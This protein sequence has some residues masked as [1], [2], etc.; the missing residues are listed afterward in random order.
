[1][2]GKKR[3]VE[4]VAQEEEAFPRGGGSG[5][6]PIV[7]KQI[8]EDAYK[9]AEA[10]LF[11][12][13]SKGRGKK[14]RKDV[15]LDSDEEGEGDEE[16][17]FFRSLAAQDK[18]PKYVEL[19]KF[20]SLNEGTK[21]WGTVVEILAKELIISLPHGLRGHVAFKESSDILA[22]AEAPKN[23]NS[24][25]ANKQQAT[26]GQAQL[27]E[28]FHVGQFVRCCV[29]R[30]R[31]GTDTD[32]PTTPGSSSGKKGT[33]N[34]RKRVD[35]SL[36]VSKVNSGLG[37]DSVREGAALPACVKSVE[38][39]GYLVTF[40][41]RGTT[42]FLPKKDSPRQLFTG[43]LVDVV[44]QSLKAGGHAIV[45]AEPAA[46]AA[47]TTKEWDGLNIGTLLPGALVPARVRHVLSD[48]LLVSFLTFFTGT[49][50]PFH[51]GPSKKEEVA[52][53]KDKKK[54]KKEEE[55]KKGTEKASLGD[56]RA[57]YSEN[58][59]IK[60]R[61]LF[62]D[63]ASKRVGL[64]LQRHLLEWSLPT[65]FPAQGQTFSA[66][67]VKRVDPGLG[68]LLDLVDNS[69][70]ES[71]KKKECTTI[72]PGYAHISNLADQKIDKLE[73][74]YRPGQVLGA[75]VIGLRPMDGLASLSLK[76]SVLEQSF[77]G[78][79]DVT[80][81]MKVTGTV[82]KSDEGALIVALT[83]H[84]K[85]LV[86]GLHMS[87]I[88]STKAYK[89]YKEGQKVTGKVLQVDLSAKK[90]LLTLKPS[91]VDSKL[92]V[93]AKIEDALPGVK[94]HG[95]ITGVQNYGVFITFF[96]DLSGLVPLV[97]CGLPE[98]QTPQEAFTI[99]SVI[100]VRVVGV[101]PK[102]NRLKLS[103]LGKKKA[104]EIAEE[105]EGLGG[106]QPGELVAGVVTVL[107]HK[108]GNTTADEE[109]DNE[110]LDYAEVALY[111]SVEL[112]TGLGNEAKPLATGRLEKAH[113]SDHPAAATALAE[114]LTV[115]SQFPNLLVLQRLETAK[116]LRVTRK[117]SLVSAAS[118]GRLP[119]EISALSEGATYPGYVA[120]VISDGV[121]VRFLG[122]LTG[123]AGLPQLSDTFVSDPHSV[124]TTGQSVRAQV[125]LIDS[126][127]NRFSLSLK[128]SLCGGGDV[129]MLSSFFH[130]AELAAALGSGGSAEVGAPADLDWSQTFAIGSKVEGQVHGVRDYGTLCDLAAHSD[131]VGLA[132]PTQVPENGPTTEGAPVTAVVLDYSKKDG[133]VDLSLRHE[134]VSRA[135]EAA[136][137]AQP[138]KK[139]KTKKEAAAASQAL[140]CQ[141]GDKISVTVELV[142]PDEGYAV[143]SLPSE[144]T[145]A[146]STPWL[147]YLATSDFNISTAAS[148]AGQLQVGDEATV[149]VAA[150]PSEKT[151][152]RLLLSIPLS[153]D[154]KASAGDG[155]KQGSGE[156][157]L[158]LP[159]AGTKL[160]GKIEAVHALHADVSLENGCRGRIYITEITDTADDEKAASV[161]KKAKKAKS[162]AKKG[163]AAEESPSSSSLSSPVSSLTIGSSIEVVVLGRMQSAE[164]KRHGL[165]ELSCRP[166]V[167]AAATALTSV[168]NEAENT[169]GNNNNTTLQNFSLQNLMVT[170]DN[171]KPG[172][173]LPGYAQE[174]DGEHLW[175]VFSPS[176][177]GRVFL[178]QSCTSPEECTAAARAYR[179]GTAITATVL[180]VNP[181]KHALDVALGTNIPTKAE[182]GGTAVGVVVSANG[183]GVQI[184]I[185]PGQSGKV[186]LT[187]IHD[188]PVNNALTGLK[189]RQFVHVGII[190]VGDDNT[191]SKNNKRKKSGDGAT[192]NQNKKNS[193]QL[194]L[195]PSHGGRCAAHTSSTAVLTATLPPPPESLD[196]SELKPGE[197]VSGYVKSSGA[198]GVFICL[199]RGIDARIKLRQLSDEFV[200]NVGKLYP[201]GTYVEGSV[202][203]VEGGRVEMTLRRRR[204]APSLEALEE[205]QVVRGRVKRI[206][207][208]GVFVE[209]DGTSDGGAT[210][211]VGPCGLAHLSELADAYVHDVDHLFKVDQRVAA[212]VLGVD[213]SAGRLSLGLKPSYFEDIS[214]VEEEGDGVAQQ[215]GDDFDD[216]LQAAAMESDKD[217]D[218]DS[219]EYG[220]EEERGS[221]S[222]SDK[223]PGSD[224]DLDEDLIEA[225][226]EEGEESGT[227]DDSE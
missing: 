183:T 137:G 125:A 76:Q 165:L 187:D 142:K 116:Q 31:E 170:W 214:D 51:L 15:H 152:G 89:K 204:P 23:T 3:N 211:S 93:L 216:E 227:D 213:K 177:R 158:K 128:R 95:V 199:A 106:L 109:G 113:L 129:S 32:T 41:I 27:S 136:A 181:G 12:S 124:F 96:N 4:L 10:D 58:Q 99:G 47:A 210:T 149:T 78:A 212:R 21:L 221:D 131:V 79:G 193:L 169:T 153:A 180:S 77:L 70:A 49:V 64:S 38:D 138:A 203:G 37:A 107:H 54:K 67:V 101:E 6:A 44:V 98:G 175:V 190:N 209:L 46:V 90:L 36:H 195:R 155:P 5:L 200:E 82:V 73:G 186:A 219:E 1:M 140:P 111:R 34:N 202:M 148:A 97:E 179:P 40:G 145:T 198:T 162:A 91:L 208:F 65:N 18:I 81:G 173:T 201:P 206:E 57:D 144:Y 100:R 55:E 102:R 114:V 59:R 160:S 191:N 8:R 42:G 123:R 66:A 182:A 94:S 166:S 39:H 105:A 132:A 192:T 163:K 85:A 28:L 127:K 43:S 83:S 60:A 80:A 84:L 56:W 48:G 197:R 151:C 7:H 154:A 52:D 130:D 189:P 220:A 110:V 16:D 147:G 161:T 215:E 143:V 24:H 14:R 29:T 150:L 196:I 33:S 88:A 11:K 223:E 218:G 53:G 133:V 141:E 22:T 121:F 194:S 117:D 217:D 122:D 13:T 2:P 72:T 30:L 168:E 75:R 164:G 207:K 119:S 225:E 20:K 50:D 178:P 156:K 167:L 25:K 17:A 62:V 45:S 157:K 74:R 71:D 139:K 112:E 69:T 35:L 171:I 19:L 172:Q 134:L 135:E 224:F 146:S 226:A 86:P 126:T 108:K 9:E 176:I 61:I 118:A 103:L 104:A 222:G 184:Q 115:G 87:D 68:L 185:A 188:T 63:A 92:P 205:G 26:A 120:N 159:A 174:V